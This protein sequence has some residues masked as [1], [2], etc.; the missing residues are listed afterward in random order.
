MCYGR[1]DRRNGKKDK[2]K[3]SRPG[4]AKGSGEK[5]VPQ[6]GAGL[7]NKSRGVP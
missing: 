7:F 5:A 2:K 6:V 3:N 1:G 4:A